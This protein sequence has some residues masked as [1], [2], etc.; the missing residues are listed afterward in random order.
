MKKSSTTAR[1]KLN[2]ETVKVLTDAGLRL[3]AA[4]APVRTIDLPCIEL[5]A[6]DCD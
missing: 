6:K 3:V 2:R 5:T 4:G 1:L